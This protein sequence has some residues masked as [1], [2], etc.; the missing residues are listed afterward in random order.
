MGVCLICRHVSPVLYSVEERQ[1]VGTVIREI[2][3]KRGLEVETPSKTEADRRLE[4]LGALVEDDEEDDAPQDPWL[5]PLATWLDGEPRTVTVEEAAK[6]IGLELGDLTAKSRS[7]L[8]GLL[9]QLGQT[10]G[11]QRF[12]QAPAHLAEVSAFVARFV[13]EE[14]TIAA[15]ASG[16]GWPHEHRENV[17][18]GR[19]LAYLGYRAHRFRIGRTATSLGTYK[20]VYRKLNA[21]LN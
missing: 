6:G 4:A 13:G 14:L 21:K 17:L 18:I 2:W 15:V 11:R 5:A 19:C 16:L 3:E 9:K 12:L 20:A 8:H 1:L 10:V 7:R